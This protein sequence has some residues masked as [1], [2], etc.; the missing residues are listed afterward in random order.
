[1]FIFTVFIPWYPGG[2]KFGTVVHFKSHLG[3]VFAD[4]RLFVGLKPTGKARISLNWL[5]AE[6][7]EVT[8]ASGARF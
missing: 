8:L 5:L 3:V 6:R 4:K 1:M 7:T 2:N